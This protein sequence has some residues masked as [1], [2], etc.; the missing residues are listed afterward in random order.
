MHREMH[1]SFFYMPDE[2]IRSHS[3]PD[4]QQY[5]AH[6]LTV[7]RPCTRSTELMYAEYK[8]HVRDE[9]TNY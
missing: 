8:A 6:V 1:P 7:Q 3:V 9:S 4:M 2:A 5:K